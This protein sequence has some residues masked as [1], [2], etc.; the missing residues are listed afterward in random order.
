MPS[1]EII[2]KAEDL[3]HS[4]LTQAAVLSRY[5]E[6]GEKPI[7]L[8]EQVIRYNLDKCR[9]H[10]E[11]LERLVVRWRTALLPFKLRCKVLISEDEYCSST[12]VK[13]VVI[14]KRL[15]VYHCE[16]CQGNSIEVL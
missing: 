3:R 16:R 6:T 8:S 7:W 12:N 5:L 13:V 4:L 14:T 15:V 11:R 10:A 9:G 2:E 1:L